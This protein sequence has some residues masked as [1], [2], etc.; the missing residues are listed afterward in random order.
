MNSNTF[1]LKRAA[2]EVDC[3]ISEFIL[4]L[5][6]CD[7]ADHKTETDYEI[8]QNNHYRHMHDR[9]CGMRRKSGT[10]DYGKQ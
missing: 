9:G 7:Q 4:Y 1:Q 8:I 6:V 2:A 5:Y 3:R 10:T